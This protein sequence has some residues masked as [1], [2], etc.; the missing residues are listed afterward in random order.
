MYLTLKTIHVSLVFISITGFTL[1]C[2]LARRES[3]ILRQRWIRIVP[4]VNDTLLLASAL[5]MVVMSAQY[6]FVVG[7]LTAKVLGLLAYIGL[8]V[9]AL[10]GRTAAIRQQAFIAALLTFGWIVSVALLR[11]PAGVFSLLLA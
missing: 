3:P 2:F 4:H 1:R 8:G 5:A 9:F 6:P 10:R 11:H 7:W